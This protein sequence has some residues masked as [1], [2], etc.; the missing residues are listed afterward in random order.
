MTALKDLTSSQRA[1]LKRLNIGIWYRGRMGHWELPG[2]P[3][4]TADMAK[5]LTRMNLAFELKHKGRIRL[6]TT[7]FAS[8][9]LAGITKVA[10]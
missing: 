10:S 8:N 6:T 1:A 5:E 3:R 7:Q 4:I 9:L 2:Q